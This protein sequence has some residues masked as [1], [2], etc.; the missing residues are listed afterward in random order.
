MAEPADEPDHLAGKLW[1]AAKCVVGSGKV[2][3]DLAALEAALLV[4]LTAARTHSVGD[5]AAAIAALKDPVPLAAAAPIL[6]DLSADPKRVAAH[7]AIRPQ[8]A[9]VVVIAAPQTLQ[10]APGS[11][12]E[13]AHAMALIL[14]AGFAA[15]DVPAAECAAGAGA[16]ADAAAV[17]TQIV[18]ATHRFQAVVVLL[19]VDDCWYRVAGHGTA[20]REEVSPQ[21]SS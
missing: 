16:T 13:M 20:E 12:A 3:Q 1:H 21:R 6:V 8:S 11:P 5:S 4:A 14:M 10:M 18:D 7:V 17:L 2:C 15:A 19:M 9:L